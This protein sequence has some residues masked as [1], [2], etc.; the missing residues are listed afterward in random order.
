[1]KKGKNL[2]SRIFSPAGLTFRFDQEIGKKKKNKTKKLYR[3]AKTKRTQHHH[4][5]FETNAKGTS[6]G[7]KEKITVRDKKVMN[8]KADW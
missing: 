3:Q 5:S 8:G 6:Q 2:Q 1:V 4:T 7:G